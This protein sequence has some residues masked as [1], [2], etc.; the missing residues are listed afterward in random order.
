MSLDDQQ[1]FERLAIDYLREVVEDKTIVGVSVA[2]MRESQ[3]LFRGASGKTCMARGTPVTSETN[4]PIASITKSLTAAAILRLAEEFGALSLTSK[5]GDF[6]DDFPKRA[7][8][9]TIEQLLRHTSG[10]VDFVATGEAYRSLEQIGAEQEEIIALFRDRPLL[11]SPGTAFSYCNSGYFL[12]GVILEKLTGLNYLEVL[13]EYVIPSV[14]G[15]KFAAPDLA[16]Q[17]NQARGHV[18][19]VGDQ[20]KITYHGAP[21][22]SASVAFSAGALCSTA[23]ALARWADA[24]FAGKVLERHS[25]AFMTSPGKLPTGA[26]VPYGAGLFLGR[27]D[28]RT[29]FHHAG[30][31][32]GFTSQL[33]HIPE[34]G[35]TV[36]V[37]TNTQG[38]FPHRVANHLLRLYRGEEAHHPFNAG[39]PPAELSRFVGTYV[40]SGIT[41]RSRT[42]LELELRD[43]DLYLVLPDSELMLI[44]RDSCQF[45]AAAD[46]DV[47]LYFVND[48]QNQPSSFVLTRQGASLGARRVSP[49]SSGQK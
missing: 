20:G 41:E 45:E 4:F 11:F 2:I 37:L 30:N 38:A 1:R 6:F 42:T 18:A 22:V 46:R 24:L 35:L 5:L 27:I 14:P 48:Q 25:L 10:L 47:S 15:E 31:T 44:Q 16:G 17:D 34:E 28:G 49:R 23:P 43:G 32:R 13:R 26:V 39:N 29:V 9:I 21:M 3:L 33:T 8:P 7:A 40:L 12:L 36:V 19:D